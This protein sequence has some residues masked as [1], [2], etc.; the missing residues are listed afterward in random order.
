MRVA[1][2]II[3]VLQTIGTQHMFG[4]P[5][6]AIEP[7]FDACANSQRRGGI[8]CVL[9]RSEA[10]AAFAA[11]GYYRESKNPALVVSTTG[12]GATNLITGLASAKTERI[13]VMVITAQTDLSKFGRTALQE[14]SDCGIDTVAIFSHVTQ[15]STAVTHV[16]Q[17]IPKLA[18]AINT[19]FGVVPGPVH[20]SIPTDILRAE[21]P[22]KSKLLSFDRNK[23][24]ASAISRLGDS[25]APDIT[26]RI[27]SADRPVF[28]FGEFTEDDAE[29]LAAL[30][31]RCN[32]PYVV[33]SASKGWF[34]TADDRN[35]GVYGFAGHEPLLSYYSKPIVSSRL[36][37]R[38][39]R[40][41]L[42]IGM[43]YY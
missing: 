39:K 31:A 17:V 37:L 34:A 15:F 21:M 36:V 22:V 40:C 41:H 1:E 28:Y 18:T 7:M 13:P 6:G 8:K 19:M 12:P 10:G 33:G 24:F 4:V 25:V 32:I 2:Y 23:S 29:A 42:V 14:S 5:G 35:Y 26:N 9:T 11:D 43:I 38:F 16:D 30:A 20:L 27:N 3:E